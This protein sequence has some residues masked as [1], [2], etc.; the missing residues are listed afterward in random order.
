MSIITD[1]IVIQTDRDCQELQTQSTSINDTLAARLKEARSRLGWSLAE[2]SRRT[3]LSRAY[4]NALELGRGKRPG[5]STLQRLED[6]L[7]PLIDH[8]QRKNVAIPSGLR[9]I[10]RERHIPESEVRVLAS[11]RI[12]GLQ[13]QTEQRWRFIYDALLSSESMDSSRRNDSGS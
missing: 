8:E 10:A 12:R 1:R 3:G 7:G 6:A 13:P 2:V 11:L 9:T 4:V 5:A